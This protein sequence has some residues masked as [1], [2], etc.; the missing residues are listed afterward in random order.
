MSEGVY[1]SASTLLFKESAE[2]LTRRLEQEG[3]EAA[4]V[5]AAEAHEIAGRLAVWHLE[6]PSDEERFATL[7][8]LFDLNRRAADYLAA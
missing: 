1:Q 6:R 2:D 7:Q 8:R 3:S 4:R 5:L